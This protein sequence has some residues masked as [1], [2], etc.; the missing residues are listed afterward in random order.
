MKDQEPVEVL[1]VP[2]RNNLMDQHAA[3][4]AEM[5]AALMIRSIH[6]SAGGSY[7]AAEVHA[8]TAMGRKKEA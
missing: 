1:A 2:T 5:L 4:I 3:R 8:R 6:V 7:A